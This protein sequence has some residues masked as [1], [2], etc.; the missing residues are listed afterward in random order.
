[1]AIA[2]GFG[3]RVGI[4]DNIWFDEKRSRPVTNIELIKKTH[5]LISI[6]QKEFFKPKEFGDL[7]FYNS[8]RND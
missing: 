4:E 3:V 8:S 6:N 2:M 1:M 7:G 5:D